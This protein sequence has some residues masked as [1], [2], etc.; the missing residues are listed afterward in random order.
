MNLTRLKIA[1][2]DIFKIIKNSNPEILRKSDL[3]RLLEQ[4]RI[5]WRL[6]A[7]TTVNSFITFLL[8][9]KILQK[10]E[11]LFPNRREIRYTKSAVS[12]YELLL[13]L[14]KNTYF[15]HYTAIY[16]NNLTEQIPKAI[17][18]NS[19]QNP[20]PTNGT[21][22]QQDRI[23][24][25]FRQNVRT[26]K[27]KAVYKDYTIFLLNGK[28]TNNLGVFEMKGEN[29]ET[30]SVTNLERT[31]LDI[32]VRPVYS[33]G[34]FEVLKAYRMARGRISVNKMA[35]MLKRI[36]FVYPYHQA[37]GFY[38]EKAG[39]NETQVD[40]FR[41]IERNYDFYL[42]HKMGDMDYSNNWRLFFPKGF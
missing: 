2:P 3:A 42:V 14:K 24:F 22:L 27:Y 18:L 11:F 23:D 32:T 16:L 10:H 33:G 9:E 30:I 34:V 12:I 5:F 39:Y 40:I 28:H 19:E 37:V 4:N 41:K 29:G 1:S 26:S 20:K 7:T 17:Y 15:S 8:K 36:N 21:L 35:A 31:L 25:A 13:T 6:T 38:L